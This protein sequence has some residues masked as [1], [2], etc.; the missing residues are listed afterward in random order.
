MHE[1]RPLRSINSNHAVGFTKIAYDKAS[2]K[3][4]ADLSNIEDSM[5]CLEK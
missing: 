3:Q 1:Q 2:S 5:V 4:H